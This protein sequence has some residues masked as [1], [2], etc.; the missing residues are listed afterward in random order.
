MSP[1]FAKKARTNKRH[2]SKSDEMAK[3]DADA[4]G[5][6]PN[7]IELILQDDK[8][9]FEFPRPP[10]SG[11]RSS[12]PS[13]AESSSD[14]D[15]EPL[16]LDDDGDGNGSAKWQDS[17]RGGR[18]GSL[19]TTRPAEEHGDGDG[20]QRRGIPIQ[21]RGTPIQ[22]RGIPIQQ[23]G[24]PI[25]GQ[26]RGIPIPGHGMSGPRRSTWDSEMDDERVLEQ[27]AASEGGFNR[28][29]QESQ[30]SAGTV[31]RTH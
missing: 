8:L 28:W 27:L 11:L 22:Q 13:H 9:K 5:H 14:S 10:C 15:I 21:Q 2:S 17:S 30:E 18:L 23:R 3:A 24:I 1:P 4:S 20:E 6:N 26:R 19:D 29:W 16:F 7:I 12:T 31:N 25:S